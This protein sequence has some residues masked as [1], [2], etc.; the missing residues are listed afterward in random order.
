MRVSFHASENGWKFR[1]FC[2]GLTVW[3]LPFLA[4]AAENGPAKALDETPVAAP[5]T[6]TGPDNEEESPW[7]WF[8]G[9]S[10]YHNKLKTSERRIDRQI[11]NTFG[12]IFPRWRRVTTFQD[13]RDQWYVWDLSCGVG[14]DINEKL[15][16]TVYGGG[17]AGTIRNRDDYFAGPVPVTTKVYFT[18]QSMFAG[19]S[20]RWWPLG[21]P[22]KKEQGLVGSLKGTRPVTEMNVGYT[23]QISIADVRVYTPLTGDRLRIRQEDKSNLLWTS[24]R[25]G[26][27]IP[28]SGGLSLNVLG[29][30]LFFHDEADDYNGAI[31]EFLISGRF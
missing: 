13:W 7:F 9:T 25:A 17:G 11:N 21:R 6:E 14:R 2:L 30:Y 15:A 10:N 4:P 28:L 12:L 16:W 1:I 18:R 31:L 29:G 8:F 26:V 3:L 5:P 23:R 20:L 19:S 22:E 24:P 27:D